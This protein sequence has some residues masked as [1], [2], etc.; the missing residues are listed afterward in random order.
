MKKVENIRIAI[1]LAAYNGMQ[2]LPEQLA[3]ILAQRD[4]NV[5]VYVSVDCSTDD[6]EAWINAAAQ[7][8]A[9][10]V[11]LPHGM[12][13]GGAARNFFRL[14]QDV[15]FADFNYVGLADQDDVWHPDKLA[16][17]VAE[18]RRSGAAGYSSNVLAFWSSG[19][20]MLI[21]KSQPQKE[22]DFL[23]EAAGPGCTYVMRTDLIHAL[24][25]SMIPCWDALQS[26]DAHDWFIYAYARANGLRWVI[27]SRPGMRYRQHTENLV[28]ANVGARAFLV[29]VRRILSGWWFAQAILVA[30]L[31]GWENDTYARA[32]QNSRYLWLACHAGQC[33][34]RLRDRIGFAVFCILMAC[35]GGNRS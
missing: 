22:R 1:C 34:R 19:R 12:R 8:D 17:A 23:F 13:F 9:R 29:R 28:G 3:S 2:W 31:V 18:L 4:V 10:I 11:V 24:K 30:R 15:D 7:R 21:D 16:R 33:R 6:T 5:T 26:V 20:E 14:L 32:L 35:K 27:D 25:K